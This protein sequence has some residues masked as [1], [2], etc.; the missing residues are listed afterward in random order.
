MMVIAKAKAEEFVNGFFGFLS[1]AIEQRD[2][3]G[4]FGGHI[5]LGNGVEVSHAAF[6]VAKGKSARI[7]LFTKC[8]DCINRLFVTRDRRSLAQAN[9]SIRA[10]ELDDSYG[11]NI[12]AFGACDGPFVGEEE[13]EPFEI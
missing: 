10:D 1:R 6:D 12:S 7:H 3:D 2:V 8:F 5:A 9:S 13:F 11:G 4:A